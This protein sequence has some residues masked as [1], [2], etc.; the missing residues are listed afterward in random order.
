MEI[1]VQD[2]AVMYAGTDAQRFAVLVR[3]KQLGATYLRQMLY[4]GRV[5]PCNGQN[6]I[7]G[8][9]GLYNRIVAEARGAGLK[10]QIVLTGIAAAW[11]NVCGGKVNT[12]HV[13]VGFW[14]KFIGT[15]V[16]FF[17]KRG[18]RRFSLYNEPNLPSFLCAGKVKTGKDV[19]SSKCKAKMAKNA[20]YYY[21]LY[22]EG[23]KTIRSLQKKKLI[24][25]GVKIWIGEYAGSEG[26]KFTDMMLKKHK[27]KADGFSYHPYQYCT[28]PSVKGKKFTKGLC[29]RAMHGIGYV[30][31]VQKKLAGWAKSK[32]LT[33]PGG[34]RVPLYLTEFGYHRKA[35][36]SIPEKWRAKWYPKAMAYAAKAGV[37]GFV[38]YQMIPQAQAWDTSILEAN[39][40]PTP[41]FRA[42]HKWAKSKGYKTRPL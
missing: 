23:Y 21:K 3:A 25:K 38:L 39:G 42:I 10:T 32:K 33:T 41:S 37:K 31:D 36:Y 40:A 7:N 16:P 5:H 27:L 1:A 2:E 34:K 6:A 15:W 12:G 14:K 35:P 28:A 13:S 8:V 29:R 11:G 18:V 19:D 9:A 26:T 22:S 24:G 20:A 4:M 30:K 17:Y